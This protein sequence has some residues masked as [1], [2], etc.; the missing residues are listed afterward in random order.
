M[1]VSC[2]LVVVVIMQSLPQSSPF[3]FLYTVG[4]CPE[5]EISNGNTSVIITPEEPTLE[6]HYVEGTIVTVSCKEGYIGSGNSTCQRNG[7]WTSASCSCELLH[8]SMH[9]HISTVN[10]EKF[11]DLILKVLV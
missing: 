4:T 6:G 11:N 8:S 9:A 1:C 3:F 5:L 7:N 2:T 10:R